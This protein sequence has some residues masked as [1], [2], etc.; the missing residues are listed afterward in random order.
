MLERINDNAYK[1]DLPSKYGN[2]SATFNVAD[3]SLYDAGD[4]RTNLFEEGGNDEDQRASNVRENN[5]NDPLHGLG[6]PTTRTRAKRAKE[7]LYGLVMKLQVEESYFPS[8]KSSMDQVHI[9]IL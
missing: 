8:F 1:I 3:L 2:V 6:G 5:F 7:A 9:N 4:S